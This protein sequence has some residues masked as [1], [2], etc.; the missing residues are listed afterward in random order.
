MVLVGCA[1]PMRSATGYKLASSAKQKTEFS[2][3]DERLIISSANLE[4]KTERS[5]SL[6]NEVMDIAIKYD[7]Y[8]LSSGNEITTIR[9]PAISFEKALDDIEKLG[10]VID[11]NV[12]GKDVTEQYRD[13]EIRLENAAKT[14]ERYLALL[15]RADNINEILKLE[16]ELERFNEKIESLKGSLKRLTHLL[17]YSSITVKTFE[18]IK[19]GPIGY[20]VYQIYSGVK[21]LFVRN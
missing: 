16:K 15:E 12:S 13:L 14:R 19:P 1:S 4:I 10:K 8:V 17:Q 11:K 2:N 3:L 18:R 20:A 5:D 21:W 7:G 6:H 9:L